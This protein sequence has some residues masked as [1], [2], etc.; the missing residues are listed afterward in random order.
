MVFSIKVLSSLFFWAGFLAISLFIGTILTKNIAQRTWNWIRT[1]ET[2][3]ADMGFEYVIVLIANY[4]CWPLVLVGFIIK[5]IIEYI[6]WNIMKL[7]VNV[8][9][10]I[11]LSVDKIIPN[12]KIDIS[13]NR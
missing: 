1:G 3:G 5:F 6:I 10:G 2:T 4:L 9:K 13:R 8:M 12:I 11:V 7:T